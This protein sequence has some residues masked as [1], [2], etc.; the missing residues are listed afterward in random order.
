MF[1]CLQALA[2]LLAL[3]ALVALVALS[4]RGPRGQQ[5][6]SVERKPV[7]P[8]DTVQTPPSSARRA[9]GSGI[10]LLKQEAVQRRSAD[11]TWPHWPPSAF[12]PVLDR[13]GQVPYVPRPGPLGTKQ[14]GQSCRA[15]A[16][17]APQPCGVSSGKRDAISS[18][19]SSTWGLLPGLRRRAPAA[20]PARPPPACAKNLGA[21]SLQPCSAPQVCQETRDQVVADRLSRQEERRRDWVLATEGAAGSGRRKI[22]LL[23][24]RTGDPLKLPP[25]PKIGYKVMAEHVDGEKDAAFRRLN[26]WLMGKLQAPNIS[27]TTQPARPPPL[28]G[29]G[30]E[31]STH[32]PCGEG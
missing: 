15:P 17:P 13:R 21:H 6:G 18:S 30:M 7:L 23:R 10:W 16:A 26:S 5:A 2:A 31:S 29:P 24:R 19:Y 9:R 32:D 3:A 4:A 1:L 11:G 14:R 22:P 20:S 27:S 12:R 28:P 8:A 25:P